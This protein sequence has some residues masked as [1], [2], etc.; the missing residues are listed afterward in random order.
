MR[1]I[2]TL[3]AA[4]ALVVLASACG[5]G[6]SVAGLSGDSAI[7]TRCHGGRDNQTGAPPFDAHGLEASPA[8]GAHTT[9][10]NASVRCDDCHVVPTQVDFPR[11]QNG[12]ADVTFGGPAVAEGATPTWTAASLTCASVYCHAPS[13][14]PGGTVP[15]PIWSGNLGTQKCGA[16]HPANGTYGQADVLSVL[17]GVHRCASC[18]GETNASVGCQA[19]HTGYQRQLGATAPV[20][21]P[22]LHVDGVAEVAGTSVPLLN[23][24]VVHTTYDRSTR[25]CSSDC[26]AITG[27]GVRNP[28]FWE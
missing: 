20:T 11:H 16:C 27:H 14:A 19:C 21:N 8:V 13:T 17:H 24:F 23:N 9:H 5:S 28:Q 3:S 12:V 18:H 26:H 15:A 10:V 1:N 2:S 7:C 4:F 22:A 25:S 6:Q